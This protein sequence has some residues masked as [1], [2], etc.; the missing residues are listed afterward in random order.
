MAPADNVVLLR[1][2]IAIEVDEVNTSPSVSNDAAQATETP[3]EPV[4]PSP[5]RTEA[6]IA[7]TISLL[8]LKQDEPLM[9]I[10]VTLFT[11]TS[12]EMCWAGVSS[13]VAKVLAKEAYESTMDADPSYMEVPV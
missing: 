11:Q 4:G 8:R 10:G 3:E 1:P 12:I 9:A 5:E 6:L 13:D 2:G 7:S